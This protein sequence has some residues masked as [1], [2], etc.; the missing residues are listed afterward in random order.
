MI[1]QRVGQYEITGKLG[2]GGMG[3]VWRGRDSRLN[4]DAAIKVLPEGGG[5]DPYR[6]QR[7]LREAQAASALNHPN[8]VTIYDVGEDWVAMECVPGQT[9]AQLIDGK[10]LRFKDAHNYA[11]QVAGALAAAHDAGIL[12]RD[13]KPG[14]IMVTPDGRVKVLDF[15]LAKP[16][17]EANPGPQEA[18]VK[19]ALTE[20]GSLL[21][22][23]A[24]MSPEQ[25]QAKKLDARSDI[26]SFG[27]VLYE[28]VT[29]R[30]AFDGDSAAST[31]SA[32]LRDDPQPATEAPVTLQ[33]VIE[34]C[35]EKNPSKRFQHAAD[36]EWALEQAPSTSTTSSAAME[37]PV[38]RIP[39]WALLVATGIG[40]LLCGAGLMALRQ[41]KPQEFWDM[42]IM[43][44][45]GRTTAAAISPDGNLVAFLWGGEGADQPDLHVKSVN[46]GQ[47]RRITN[48]PTL[49]GS[50]AW[51]ADGTR[52]AFT[53]RTQRSQGATLHVISLGGGPARRVAK[54]TV[55]NGSTLSWSPD[56]RFL[57]AECGAGICI[58]EMG[59]GEMRMV[60]TP[61]S[62]L[63]DHN[64]VFSAD[65]KRL[66][67]VRRRSFYNS[68]VF[69][70][71]LSD[72]GQPAGAEKRV[73]NDERN[74]NGLAWEAGGKNLIALASVNSL[75]RAMW[76]VSP[77]GGEM[78]RISPVAG[79]YTELSIPRTGRR[80]AFVD[81]TASS[82]IY[83]LD[84][85]Q[86]GPK[87]P[88]SILTGAVRDMAVTPDGSRI[89][90]IS[91]GSGNRDLW[92]A[93]SDGTEAQPLAR[94]GEMRV[95]SPRW[96]PDGSQIAFDAYT[97]G[98]GDIYIIGQEGGSARRFTPESSGESRPSWSRDGKW[99]YFASDR[100]GRYEVWRMPVAGGKAIQVT[101][102]GGNHPMESVDGKT[103][104]FF[105]RSGVNAI[106]RQ[107]LA[108]GE[109]VQIGGETNMSNWAIGTRHLYYADAG[110][111][112][113]FRVPLAGGE[114]ELL[115]ELPRELALGNAG[116]NL[117]V[118]DDES[119]LWFRP[120][121]ESRSHVVVV[122]NFQ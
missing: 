61:G 109:A 110:R 70:L 78:E 15:G 8:I 26:F 115:A 10:P 34:R 22:T 46:G 47:A 113:L 99:I 60:T 56:D 58:V 37:T 33:R 102:N 52:L 91:D 92:T 66:A 96:S 53:R 57:A 84:L 88:Q 50:P 16:M 89:A 87:T 62:T 23:F 9:L 41:P 28:M 73:T 49:E 27:A 3:V 38:R 25:A 20:K 1:G 81:T 44:Y 103:L 101:K 122:H 119:T 54:Q 65:G 36:I 21:G 114:P 11:R 90:F 95:G 63:S 116:T 117:A 17:G 67:F 107:D 5:D 98:G 75:G 80:L 83:K 74:I 100:S 45:S 42:E 72:Q 68:G 71:E 4:R 108:G 111:T 24:Y 30:R 32:V 97:R 86:K 106:W 6:R 40:G 31:M 35:L 120:T 59:T 118:S 19:A 94:A 14:N 79:G 48:D 82:A 39:A 29:G 121:G 112:R 69:L 12:H 55:N 93:K 64:P 85:N 18:T 76:K 104:F 43:T 13:L 2:E 77:S 7:L 105:A 51:S